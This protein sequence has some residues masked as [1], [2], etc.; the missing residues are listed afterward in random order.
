[1]IKILSV[2]ETPPF[3][4]IDP[5]PKLHVDIEIDGYSTSVGGLPATWTSTELNDYL[6]ANEADLLRKARAKPPKETYPK[7]RYD[8][9]NA[10]PD[11]EH[12]AKLIAVN[13]ALPKPATVRRWHEGIAYDVNCLVS[14]TIVN[15]WLANPK[16]LN[17]GDWVLVSFLDELTET[18][19]KNIAIVTG[20]IFK[21][22]S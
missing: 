13:P 5:E 3:D 9:G 11:S 19:W 17:I 6:Q 22:W 21:S 1:M 14:Q 4:E 20:K 16:E 10:L 2:Y 18:G 15:M 12:P 8:L 7:I